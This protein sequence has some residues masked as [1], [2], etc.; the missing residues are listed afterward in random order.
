MVTHDALTPV[1]TPYKALPCSSMVFA[2]GNLNTVAVIAVVCAH[3]STIV[4][5]P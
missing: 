4:N 2:L 3:F 1:F 5:F